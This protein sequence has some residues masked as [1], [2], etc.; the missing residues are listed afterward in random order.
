MGFENRRGA[1]KT[2][3]KNVATSDADRETHKETKRDGTCLGVGGCKK[4][5][6]DRIILDAADPKENL[7]PSIDHKTARGGRCL[8]RGAVFQSFVKSQ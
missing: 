4:R 2:L 7:C 5:R 3:V 1:G 8:V 6:A